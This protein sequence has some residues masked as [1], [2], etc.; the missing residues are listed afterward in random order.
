MKRLQEERYQLAHEIGA[1][2]HTM[3]LGD[4]FAVELDSTRHALVAKTVEMGHLIERIREQEF[5]ERPY[6]GSNVH[7]FEAR[8]QA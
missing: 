4:W 1:L 3:L 5:F 2:A 8:P 7:R 6:E